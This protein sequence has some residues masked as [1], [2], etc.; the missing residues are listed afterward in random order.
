MYHVPFLDIREN[1][2]GESRWADE[3]DSVSAKKEEGYSHRP[4]R[5]F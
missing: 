1:I 4:F 5:T 2:R 3:K